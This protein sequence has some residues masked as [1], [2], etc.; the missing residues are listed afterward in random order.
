[1][2]ATSGDRGG[3]ALGGDKAQ[4]RKV[5]VNMHAEGDTLVIGIGRRLTIPTGGTPPF[6][7]ASPKN[8]K[9]CRSPAREPGRKLSYY[10]PVRELS[11]IGMWKGEAMTLSSR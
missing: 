4:R 8:G 9:R 10:H 6:G 5:P 2:A 1:L 3:G 11:P 7:F